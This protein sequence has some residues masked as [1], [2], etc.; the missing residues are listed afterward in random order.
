MQEEKNRDIHTQFF[1]DTVYFSAIAAINKKKHCR[2]FVNG[3]NGAHLD[4]I[5]LWLYSFDS[6]VIA[7]VCVCE[8][9][10]KRKR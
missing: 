7:C 9:E 3:K 10:K 1:Y 8:R 4:C 6:I 2:V 5:A